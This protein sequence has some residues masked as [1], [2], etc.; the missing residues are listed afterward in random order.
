M[1]KMLVCSCLLAAL[2]GC[3]EEKKPQPPLSVVS[4]PEAPLAPAPI[5]DAGSMAA[6]EPAPE[7]DPVGLEHHDGRKV[8]HLARARE[9]KSLGELD[10]ALAEARRAVFDDPTDEEALLLT[11]QL[12]RLA[13]EKAVASEAFGRLG[14][15]RTDDPM[16]LIQQARVLLSMRDHEGAATVGKE[17][18]ERDPENAEGWHVVG[19]A[20]LN[21]GNLAEAIEMFE[22]AVE[23]NPEHGYA[24]NNL[25]FA[26]LRA[27]ENEKALEALK[28]AAEL[29]PHVAYVHNNLGVALERTGDIEGAKLAYAKSTSLSP[30]YVK[31]KVNAAR[32]AKANVAPAPVEEE[33]S[34]ELELPEE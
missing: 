9:M 1:R 20:R 18:I 13:G 6:T 16:P 27:N 12:A 4:Q 7:P 26:C 14:N 21:Q 24:L 33:L 10:G 19:R 15:L 31:A 32:V 3:T 8:D 2:F 22:R 17:A 11:A 28:R 29:L 34:P 5:A 23:I 25:G 30:K